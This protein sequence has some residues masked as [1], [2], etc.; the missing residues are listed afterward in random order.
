MSREWLLA[1][2]GAVF[3][4]VQKVLP[5]DVREKWEAWKWR[6]AVYYGG[7]TVIAIAAYCLCR[8]LHVDIGVD[9]MGSVADGILS[10]F[11]TAG[12]V[13][14]GLNLS[15]TLTGL[16]VMAYHAIKARIAKRRS[17]LR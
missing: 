17:K 14:L 11:V 4:I 7:I 6:E 13:F 10:C 16:G 15:S 8:F 5:A 1:V 9:C 12:T 2:V 3:G